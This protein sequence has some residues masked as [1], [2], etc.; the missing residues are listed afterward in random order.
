MWD[1]ARGA[2]TNSYDIIL[3]TP[4]NGGSSVGQPVRSYLHKL[5]MDAGC[6]LEELLGAMDDRD[7]WR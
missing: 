5:C 7:R 2:R 6:S 1:T 4:E 3:W